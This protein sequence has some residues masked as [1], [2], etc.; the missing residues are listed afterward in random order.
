VSSEAEDRAHLAAFRTAARQIRDASVIAEG[1]QV[2]LHGRRSDAGE[3]LI[4][5]SLL[6]SE[7]FRSLALS[8]RLVYQANEPANFGHV[9]NILCRTGNET[10]RDRAAQIRERYNQTLSEHGC[11]VTAVAFD[12][13]S[14][15][16]PRDVFE[17]WLYHGVFHQDLS[18][19]ADWRSLSALG[20]KFLFLVQGIVLK[21]AG[22]IMD[23]D[24]VVADFL[25]EPRID[26]IGPSV[27][28]SH[29]SVADA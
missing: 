25:L 21:L 1:R 26:R 17:T 11:V 13:R 16:S 19:D 18:R 3:M 9:C 23:L 28:D 5:A 14:P 2:Q 6:E 10:T 24:D 12:D 8:V 20:D 7:P 4:T 29:E 22:R 15:Y 27:G